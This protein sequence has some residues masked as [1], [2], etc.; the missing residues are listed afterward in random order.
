MEQTSW[1]PI[2]S[3][4]NYRTTDP[5]LV[6]DIADWNNSTCSTVMAVEPIGFDH[7]DSGS[8]WRGCTTWVVQRLYSHCFQYGQKKYNHSCSGSIALSE[9]WSN[10]Q[11]TILLTDV[12]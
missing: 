3:A 9:S 7:V 12:P 4:M 5:M 8:G 10:E 11:R 6:V 1:N 2:D